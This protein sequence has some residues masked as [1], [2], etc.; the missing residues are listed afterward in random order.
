[1]I[2]SKTAPILSINNLFKNPEKLE[3]VSKEIP[4]PHIHYAISLLYHYLNKII[5]P[6]TEETQASYFLLGMSYEEARVRYAK[7]NYTYL[8]NC[9][10]YWNKDLNNPC[11]LADLGTVWANYIRPWEVSV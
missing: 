4:C 2:S 10:K 11:N 1:M 8:I 6:F 3:I 9:L 7:L 5:G